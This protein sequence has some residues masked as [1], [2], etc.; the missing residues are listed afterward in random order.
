MTQIPPQNSFT[1]TSNEYPFAPNNLPV[2]DETP[3]MEESASSPTLLSSEKPESYLQNLDLSVQEQQTPWKRFS[4]QAFI[5]LRTKAT[6]LA[7]AIGTIPVALV[8]TTAYLTASTG[9]KAEI[10]QNEQH[11]T[12]S[13]QQKLNLFVKQRYE[14]IVILSKFDA[15]TNSQVRNS[16]TS[17]GKNAILKDWIDS[18]KI[19]NS[20]VVYNPPQRETIAS[21]GDKF[22]L[23][24]VLKADY[25]Q[26]VLETD[27]PIIVD[28]RQ[29]LTQGVGFSFYTAAPVKDKSTNK[30]V[31]LVRTRA[32]MAAV[33][34]FFY[35]GEANL[36]REF[37][38]TDS[39]GK[40]T[41]SSNPK[42]V[43]KNLADLFPKLSSRLQ[44][45]GK[46]KLTTILSE[47]GQE[48]IFTYVPNEEL[49]RAYG[50]NW[51]LVVARPTV[52]AFAPQRQLLITL[53]LGT[54]FFTA[55]VAVIAIT[56]ANR[57][58]RPILEATDAV[59]KIGQGDLNTRLIVQGDDELGLLVNNINDMAGQLG[60]LLHEKERVA[61]EQRQLTELLQSRVLELLEE[62]EPINDGDLTIR[63]TVTADD[64][65]TI[66][67]SY[68][69]MVSNLREIV[70]KVQFAATNVATTTS[71]NEQSIQALSQEAVRQ[72]EEITVALKQVQEMA[73]SA[74]Q[75]ALSAEKAAE[76]VRRASQTVEEG[77]AAINRTVEGIVAI[78]ETVSQTRQK[79]K[80]LGESSQKISTVVNLISEFASQTKMLAFNASIE[81]TRA[82]EQGRGFAI[83]A[84]EVR[85]LAQQSAEASREIEKLIAAIQGET[86]EVIAAMEE[87]TEQVVMGTKLVDETR[88]TLSKI[89]VAS[90][91]VSQLV[92][93]IA[94]AAIEQSGVSETVTQTMTNVAQISDKTSQEATVVS[95]SFE[96]LQR[97]AKALQ[98]DVAQFKV[99]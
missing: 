95:S 99:S 49:R 83:V 19:Y 71:N 10:I 54:V 47:K 93:E 46:Q 44:K 50:L 56:I 24:P 81:A 21:A 72:T 17:E 16:L 89:T 15:F 98:E 60:I 69:F 28:P 32:S 14:D 8:G 84:D 43:E 41:A 97:V 5:S 64:I 25:T 67:D 2:G 45:G 23:E 76:V 52:V 48:Q 94:Q 65:G 91:E 79:V 39:Q 27:R 88:H 74:R 26:A 34:D 70:T 18:G 33:K 53:L 59:V 31:A 40:I 85:T 29:S 11:N 68:N 38:I 92:E 1:K 35:Q 4:N 22:D 36:G 75:V 37:Y 9:I 7:L 96:E 82:G 62:V 73:Q 66:A 86:N 12:A 87:G 77:D 3:V 20:I 78:R 63:A 61:D 51:S 58:T 80:Y 6:A 55:L 13:L 30:T 57:A 42:A 90:A